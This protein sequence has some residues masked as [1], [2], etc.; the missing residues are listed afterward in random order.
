VDAA[1]R[2][3]RR[4]AQSKALERAAGAWRGRD[5]PELAKGSVEWVRKL[6]SEGERR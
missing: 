1:E 2:E 5:H 6:R 4:I 3:L